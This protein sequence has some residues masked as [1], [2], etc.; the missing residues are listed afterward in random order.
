ME[1]SR[2]ALRPDTTHHARGGGSRSDPALTRNRRPPRLRGTRAGAPATT[3]PEHTLSRKAAGGP[4]AGRLPLCAA[5]RNHH[6]QR[7]SRSAAVARRRRRSLT[8][9][10][11]RTAPTAAPRRSRR[12]AGSRASSPAGSSHN[13]QFDDFDDYGLTADVALGLAAIGGHGP[14]SRQIS[15]ALAA[16]V[17]S[18]TTGADF[19]AP[20]DV[21]AG[22]SPRLTVLAQVAGDDPRAFGGVDLVQR[23]NGRVSHDRAHRRP[24]RGQERLRR[25]RQHDRPGLRRARAGPGRLGRGRRRGPV[26][27]QAA[28]RRRLLPARTSATGR[29]EARRCDAGAG[30]QNRAPDTDATALA[31]L[32]LQAL[33]KRPDARGPR[34]DRPTPPPG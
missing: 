32:D 7:V 21:Y 19:G 9:G 14:A 10:P 28:V 27:A 11:G 16:E 5:G 29:R 3:R 26:P 22:S 20:D 4:D 6:A 23:L 24:D 17:D 8:A 30:E 25:L 18:Y 33:A 34:R 12:R 1:R 2:G 13:D 31:V 15:D